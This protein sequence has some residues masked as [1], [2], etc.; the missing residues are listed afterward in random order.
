MT[1]S[2]S[3]IKRLFIGQI[4]L[5]GRRAMG[6]ILS[7]GDVIEAVGHGTPPTVECVE[8]ETFPEPMTIKQ[9]DFNAHS[10]PEQSIYTDLVDRSWDLGTWCRNT[11]YRYSPFITPKQ[12]RL[13]CRRAFGRIA[14]LGASSVMVSF[15]LHGGKGNVNDREVI[16]AAKDVGIRLIFG[17]MTYDM[18]S[19]QAYEGKKKA[20]ESYYESPDQGEAY[21][22][23]LMADEGPTVMVAPAV[24]SMHASTAQ[25]IERAIN[26]GYDLKRPVQFHLSEDQGDVDISLKEHGVRPVVFL[27]SM[28]DSCRIPGLGRLVFSDCCWLDD[29]ERSIMADCSIPVV[30]NPRMN[31]R[32]GVGESDLPSLLSSGISVFLG[33]DGEASND[34]LSVQGERE[35]LKGRYSGVLS[36]SKI[37]ALG[38]QPFQ[39]LDGEIGPLA[40]GR[41]C[42]FVVESDGRT[43]HLF[44][45][46]EPVVRDGTLVN[47]DMEGDIEAPLAE[48]IEAMKKTVEI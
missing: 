25:A 35:F 12:V 31:H 18:V 3:D 47:L 4:E 24:H 7:C 17:R 46:A 45:G 48:E 43:V 32:V 38:R 10:H 5:E 36:S 41:L 22:R 29:Q 13:A 34:D 19:P 14:L 33:T 27:K 1:S 44:V 11:I 37:E 16:A 30:L 26:L 40:P 21:L 42:D 2:V 20:Q 15:Y 28:V 8:V 23:E 39:F 9:G 6:Y